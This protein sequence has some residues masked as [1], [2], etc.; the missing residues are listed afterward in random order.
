M[1][2]PL[3]GPPILR[4]AKES[5]G[6]DFLKAAT[7]FMGVSKG[8]LYDGFFS[9]PSP[10]RLLDILHLFSLAVQSFQN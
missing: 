10:G 2:A 4:R 5:G 7:G 1:A 3:R 9:L 6:L 8:L